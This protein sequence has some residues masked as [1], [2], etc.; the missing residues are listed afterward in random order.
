MLIMIG[1]KLEPDEVCLAESEMA[2]DFLIV[3]LF[4]S[5][6]S[7]IKSH[8]GLKFLIVEPKLVAKLLNVGVRY[9]TLPADIFSFVFAQDV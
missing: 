7:R 1:L 4:R 5:E 6:G 9:Y 3:C 8:Y 2:V